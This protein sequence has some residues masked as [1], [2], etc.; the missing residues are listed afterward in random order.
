MSKDEG[1]LYKALWEK[2]SEKN[3][4]TKNKVII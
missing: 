4:K 3:E 1:K 2:Y